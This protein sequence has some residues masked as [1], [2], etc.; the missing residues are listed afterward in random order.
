MTIDWQPLSLTFRLAALTTVLLLLIGVPLAYWI[1][2]TRTRF[3]PLFEAL[4]S[5]P[6]VLPPSVLGFYLL[7]AFSP[8]QAFGA[9]IEQWFHVQLAFSFAGLVVA[10]VIFSLPFMVQPLQAGFQHLPVSLMEA[11]R[12][13]GKPDIVTLF[14]VL[15]PNMKGAVLSATVLSFAHT[16]GE[17]G[18]VLMIG[19][20]I[21]GVTRVAS[22][23]IYDQVESLQYATAHIYAGV[24]LV[25]SFV[26]LLGVYCLNRRWHRA[27]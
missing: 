24:L 16:V 26:V 8:N 20:N 6:L 25:L 27:S 19:G 3:K 14:R 22:I 23:A 9:W 18:V 12:T 21:P 11:S 7:L 17:F 1:A 5:M 2:Y 13:L 15:L 10:S 4:V